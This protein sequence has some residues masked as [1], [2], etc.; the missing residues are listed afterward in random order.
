MAN[1]RVGSGQSDYSSKRVILSELK[2]NLGQSG[3]GSGRLTR[4]FHMNFFLYIKKNVFA[5]WKVMQQIT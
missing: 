3:C 5:I 2:T 1:G 4:I